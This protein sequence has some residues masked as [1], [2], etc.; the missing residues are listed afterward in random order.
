M[1]VLFVGHGS[2]KN[3]IEDNVWSRGFKALGTAL[4]AP[5]AI[6]SISAHWY[7]RGTHTTGNPRPET[8]HD[9]SG[10]PQALYEIEY[11]A[12]GDVAPASAKM[13]CSFRCKALTWARCRCARSAGLESAADRVSAAQEKEDD[14]IIRCLSYCNTGLRLLDG[15]AGRER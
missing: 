10:F 8:I 12:A 14:T 9:F 7:V 4:P 11:P 5:R 15:D 3:A 13:Q 6:L 1:P 2:P